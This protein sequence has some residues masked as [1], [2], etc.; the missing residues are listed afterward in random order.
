VKDLQLLKR[1]QDSEI[2]LTV[3]IINDPNDRKKTN[4]TC[5]RVIKAADI[6]YEFAIGSNWNEGVQCD[7]KISVVLPT[8]DD[9]NTP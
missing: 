5:F 9:G 8:Q 6:A 7:D 4:G 1:V 3:E 2:E